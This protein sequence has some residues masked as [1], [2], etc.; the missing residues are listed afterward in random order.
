MYLLRFYTHGKNEAFYPPI[1]AKSLAVA[2]FG[3]SVLLGA[4]PANALDFT[5]SFQDVD[6]GTNGFVT[7]TLSG[8]VEGNNAG[9]GITA[10][11]TSSPGG[12]G[13]GFGYNLG[14]A[15]SPAF[16][17][18]GG[19]IT[20][21]DILFGDGTNELLLRP[22]GSSTL[23]YLFTPT[24]T[25]FDFSSATTTFTPVSAAVPFELNSTVGLAT[26]GI[27]FG[28]AKLRRKHLAKKLVV[29]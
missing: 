29:S 7:G 25:Y 4:A 11:V 9:P 24:N 15:G 16:T 28:A 6:G 17:V 14:G 8:L 1:I 23:T 12:D 5:F 18:T 21:A 20:Y 2:G 22:P 27:C 10:T 26:L 19:N 13:V 3:A